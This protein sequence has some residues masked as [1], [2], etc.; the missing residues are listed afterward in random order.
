M[1]ISQKVFFKWYDASELFDKE[2]T[3]AQRQ[4]TLVKGF[5][6]STLC[7]IP[8]GWFQRFWWIITLPLMIAFRITMPFDVQIYHPHNGKRAAWNFVMSILWIGVCAN[9]MVEWTIT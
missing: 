5:Q 8:E 7:H 9:F 2:K 4:G 1:G 3:L 6:F